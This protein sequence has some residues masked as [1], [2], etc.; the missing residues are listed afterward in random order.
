MKTALQRLP[1]VSSSALLKAP[2]SQV[3]NSQPPLD[4]YFNS[5]FTRLGPQRWWPGKTPFEIIVGAILTQSTS[6]RNVEMALTNLR[7]EGL[8]TPGAIEELHIRRLQALIRSAGYWRQ[9]A[10]ALKSFVRFLRE[11]F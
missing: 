8:L 5:L 3:S 10:R 9:K 4:E 1:I 2:T 11:E 6:W 7:G